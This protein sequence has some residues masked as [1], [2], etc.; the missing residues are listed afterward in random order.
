MNRYAYSEE[1]QLKQKQCVFFSCFFFFGVFVLQKCLFNFYTFLS[2]LATLIFLKSGHTVK[3]IC[4][5]VL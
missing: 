5:G 2:F 4:W 1:H 3:L